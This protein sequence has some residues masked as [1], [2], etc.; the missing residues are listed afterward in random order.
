VLV[1][2]DEH[3]YVS[4]G[5]TCNAC[6][7][8][9]WRRASVLR[10][11]L[12]GGTASLFARGLR[13]SV[14]L[15]FHPQTGEL[16]GSD[17]G[18]DLLGDDLP[19][20]EVNRIVAGGDYGWPYCYGERIPDPDFGTSERCRQT[21]PPQVEM[22]AH[23]APLGIAFVEG[24]AFPESYRRM[25]LVA[26]HGSW[27]R[28]VPTGYKLVGIPFRAGRPVGAA[29]D[30]VGGWLRAGIAWGRPVAPAV[31]ADGALYLSDDRAGAIYRIRYSLPDVRE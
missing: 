24:L 7:E 29:V 5:S 10:L 14:G 15:A 6:L 28:S 26:F 18:R 3:L 30:L 13:N 27:N 1:G 25:L 12:S 8:E 23:S 20:E 19:P 2:T 4:V 11:P 22:Q 31:G 16:W 17:N 9:D 21:I